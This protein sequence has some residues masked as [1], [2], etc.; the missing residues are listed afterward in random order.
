MSLCKYANAFGEPGKG[1]HSYR[2]FSVA[3]VDLG[4]TLIAAHYVAK[5]YGLSFAEA[6]TTLILLGIVAHRVFCVNTTLNV[7]LFGKIES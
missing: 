7:A 1:A 5:W 3:A 2:I 4:L 6:A